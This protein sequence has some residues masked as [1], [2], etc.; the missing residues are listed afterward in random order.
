MTIGK[1]R[2]RTYNSTMKGQQDRLPHVLILGCGRSGT[3][4]FGE[5]FKDIPE[6]EYFS[7]PHFDDLVESQ[8]QRPLA[9]KVPRESENHPPDEG[10]SISVTAT[11]NLIPVPRKI[12]WIVRHPLDTIASLKVGISRD[13]GHHPRPTDWKEWLHKPLIKQCAHHWNWINSV[14]YTKVNHLVSI[15]HFEDLVLQPRNFAQILCKD[16][17]LNPNH[18]AVNHWIDRVQNENNEKFIEAD[19][20]RSYS[21]NDHKVKVG[22]WREN[23][24]SEEVQDS[25]Q[26]VR[27][28]AM[29]FGYRL[30]N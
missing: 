14:G 13:W 18:S 1:C 7:E 15:K 9:I 16:L 30:P 11:K 8:F 22:R 24:T 17:G 10:L 21:T 27:H 2:W 26:I 25:L 4:I 20:S 5:F 23:L 3:S 29:S 6:Y 19:T 28:T 12:Y